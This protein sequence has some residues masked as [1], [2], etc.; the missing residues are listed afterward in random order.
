MAHEQKP[1]AVPEGGAQKQVTQQRAG[2]F[3]CR[4]CRTCF[5]APAGAAGVTCPSCGADRTDRLSVPE[6]AVDYVL[7]DRS[8]G[9][10]SHD[11]LFAQWAKWC[12]YVTPHQ[13]DLAIHRQNSELREDGVARPI[14]EVMVSLG[15]IDEDTSDS[16][17]RF[18]AMPRP[19]ACDEDMVRRLL[20]SKRANAQDLQRA[21]ELHRRAAAGGGIVPPIGQFMLQKGLINEVDLVRLLREQSDDGTG[22]LRLALAMRGPQ[23]T[24]GI[25]ARPRIRAAA[26]KIVTGIGL[27]ALVALVLWWALHEPVR[28]VWVVCKT[29]NAVRKVEAPQEWPAKCPACGYRTSWPAV[30]CR[31][32]HI[33]ARTTPLTVPGEACPECGSTAALPITNGDVPDR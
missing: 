31:N 22:S 15:F 8:Q 10:T 30:K 33:Y 32:G 26:R 12:N 1:E 3:R 21:C 27:A 14:H 6:G 9:T 13:Y 7:A 18:L 17:L 16:L 20:L 25:L 11:I 23:A 4:V 2:A 28:K 29:C 19:D 24:G 5:G